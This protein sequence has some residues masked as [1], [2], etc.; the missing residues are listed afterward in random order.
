[1]G[2]QDTYFASCTVEDYSDPVDAT[3][4]V[5]DI[6]TVFLSHRTYAAKSGKPYKKLQAVGRDGVIRLGSALPQSTFETGRCSPNPAWEHLPEPQDRRH[7]APAR[8]GYTCI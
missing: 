6:L 4:T 5:L 7:G 1:M 2:A 3:S 8:Q